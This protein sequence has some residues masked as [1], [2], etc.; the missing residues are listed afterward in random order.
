MRGRHY[1]KE[2]NNV[3]KEKGSEAREEDGKGKEVRCE[4]N[5]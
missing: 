4:R 2:E 3:S 5:I 1:W